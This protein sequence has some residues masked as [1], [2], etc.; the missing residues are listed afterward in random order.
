MFIL[1]TDVVSNLRRRQ[2]N[3]A[4]LQWIEAVGWAELATTVTTVMEITFGIEEVRRTD[5]GVADAV[6]QWLLGILGV[7][8]PQVL[9]LDVEA[10]RKAARRG[11]LRAIRARIRVDRAAAHPFLPAAPRFL[12]AATHH[13]LLHPHLAG[14]AS[15]VCLLEQGFWCWRVS[16]FL[17]CLHS[18][19]PQFRRLLSHL[20]RRLLLLY[21][22]AEP[23]KAKGDSMMVN[24]LSI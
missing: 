17:H 16:A 19:Q 15:L 12:L 7:G 13:H 9:P 2:P 11:V 14:K 23:G 3:T 6:E 5:P 22:V 18:V 8:E 4:L 1:D 10:A 24:H 20:R 21:S